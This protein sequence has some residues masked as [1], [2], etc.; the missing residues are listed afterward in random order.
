VVS[1]HDAEGNFS[2]SSSQIGIW[3]RVWG[4]VRSYLALCSVKYGM[5][6]KGVHWVRTMQGLHL[7]DSVW[8]GLFGFAIRQMSSPT[9]HIV[10]QSA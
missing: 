6:V 1:W 5:G 2:R 9:S 7:G 4:G 3:S 8:Q 10:Q